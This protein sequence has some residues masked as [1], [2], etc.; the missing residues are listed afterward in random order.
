MIFA[1]IAAYLPGK[2]RHTSCPELQDSTLEEVFRK[3][4]EHALLISMWTCLF[5]SL[6]TETRRDYWRTCTAKRVEIAA[7][8]RAKHDGISPNLISLSSN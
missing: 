3:M 2:E 1:D 5:S 4:G 8:I 7:G 6:P